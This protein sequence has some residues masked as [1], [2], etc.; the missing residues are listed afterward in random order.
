MGASAKEEPSDTSSREALLDRVE[1][2]T[3]LPLMVLSFAMV[4]LI[5]APVFWDLAPG[6]RAAP[7]LWEDLASL[8]GGAKGK[9]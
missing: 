9:Q 3:E 7:N 5:A 8:S 4:P 1:R 6:S 2:V